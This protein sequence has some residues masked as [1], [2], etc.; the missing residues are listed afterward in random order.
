MAEEDA[1]PLELGDLDQQ[2]PEPDAREVDVER[3]HPA[4]GRGIGLH[5][6]RDDDEADRQREDDHGEKAE[7]E[8]GACRVVT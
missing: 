3:R 7:H 4:M 5:E 8:H 2:E 6:Q 1:E